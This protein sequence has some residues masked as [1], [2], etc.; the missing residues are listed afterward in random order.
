MSEIKVMRILALATVFIL[1]V[2]AEGRAQS[3]HVGAASTAPMTYPTSPAA[4]VTP[5]GAYAF[6]DEPVMSINNSYLGYSNFIDPD[7]PAPRYIFNHR[8]AQPPVYAPAPQGRVVRWF[9][10]RRRGRL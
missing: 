4:G 2:S 10:R 8:V 7:H 5:P 9:G 3:G 1:G 6:K